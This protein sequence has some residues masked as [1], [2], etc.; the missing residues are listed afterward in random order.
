MSLTQRKY[1][2]EPTMVNGNRELDYLDATIQKMNLRQDATYVV[3][4][5][6]QG[7]PDLIANIVY[8][9][10]DLGWLISYYNDIL[11]P[12]TEYSIGKELRIPSLDDYYRFFN[13][14]ARR[15]NG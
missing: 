9:N 2:Y 4:A 7:R 5:A 6:T 14:S 15:V 12:F 10:Y 1:F 11:D 8:G 13:R 3:T